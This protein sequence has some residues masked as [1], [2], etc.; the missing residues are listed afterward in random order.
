M[1]INMLLKSISYFNFKNVEIE[2]SQEIKSLLKNTFPTVS[3][4]NSTVDLL[5]TEIMDISIFTELLSEG[6]LH[7]DSMVLVEGI[8]QNKNKWKDWENLIASPSI[9]VSIDMFHFGAIFI[10]QEQEKEH[11][12]IRI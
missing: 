10:R 8:H 6:K 4:D 9:T 3:F 2:N 11:F 12:T 7:N 1:T 5:Y